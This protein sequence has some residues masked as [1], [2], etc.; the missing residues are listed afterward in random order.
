[1]REHV[2]AQLFY[3]TLSI[4]HSYSYVDQMFTNL[5]SFDKLISQIDFLF[6]G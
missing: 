6:F 4:Y 3:K 1:M 5:L 2:V